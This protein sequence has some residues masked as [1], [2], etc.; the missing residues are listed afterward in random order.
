MCILFTNIIDNYLIIA[1]L[2]VRIFHIESSY[3]NFDSWVITFWIWLLI[4]V[5]GSI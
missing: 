2:D 3:L 4:Q 5:I 1:L